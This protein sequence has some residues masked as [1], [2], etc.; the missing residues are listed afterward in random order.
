MP[1]VEWDEGGMR[2][3]GVGGGDGS[4]DVVEHLTSHSWGKLGGDGKEK[5]DLSFQHNE[6]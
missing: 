3:G 6:P 2:D 4:H 5:V 1:E